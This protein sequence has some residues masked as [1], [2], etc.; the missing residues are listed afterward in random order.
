[1]GEAYRADHVGIDVLARPR[2][3]SLLPVDFGCHGRTH[4]GDKRDE[5]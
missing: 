2:L 5:L 3:Q 4:E 1:M